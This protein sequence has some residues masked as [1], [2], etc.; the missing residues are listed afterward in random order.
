MY[1]RIVEA[2]PEGIWAVDTQGRTIFSNR[3]MAEI[4]GTDF[5]SMPE[6][7]CFACVFPDEL[8]D[9][10]R[11]FA[12]T[13][14]GDPRPFDFRLR[15]ADG[16]P[17]WVSISCMPISDD[18]GAVGLLGLF[19]DISERKQA[20]A[21]LRESEER[22][23]NLA[24]TAPVMIWVT[25]PDKL[26]TFFNKT[27]LDFTGRTMEQELGN[28]WAR[29]VHP[30]DL[31]RCHETFCSSFDAR[32]DFRIEC[33]LRRVDG[34]YRWMLCSGVPRFAPGGI[35]AG[36]I[37]SDIDIT[38]LQSEERFRQL[39][40]NIDQIFWML[41]LRTNKILYVSPGFEKVW[42]CTPRPYTK[43]AIG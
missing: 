3:R 39:A 31:R 4:L 42:G 38:D 23:R 11:H 28:G 37:G 26:F 19:S 17:I 22:F 27:W 5:E 16:S 12:R 21:A 30:E 15:R 8:E 20:E 32:R 2:V 10:Q 34:E 36:Y 33:R 18:T 14:A 24:D 43:I 1:R 40:E 7:S 35:F 25:G 41:D 13:L 29:G 6:Q 9:A